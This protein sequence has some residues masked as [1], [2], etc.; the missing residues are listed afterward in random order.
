MSEFRDFHLAALANRSI[1]RHEATRENTDYV[2]HTVGSNG[3]VML[4][5]RV[6]SGDVRRF[7]L[8]PS[9]DA[10]RSVATRTRTYTKSSDFS[11][12]DA[13]SA[14]GSIP[15]WVDPQQHPGLAKWIVIEFIRQ[16]AAETAGALP[17]ITF[18]SES[19][20][21]IDVSEC[22]AIHHS[23][24]I[25]ASYSVG[26][27]KTASAYGMSYMG[28]NWRMRRYSSI[29]DAP[30][31]MPRQEATINVL[32]LKGDTFS[33]ALDNETGAPY[34]DQ[35]L[36][37]YVRPL[38]RHLKSKK[39]YLAKVSVKRDGSGFVTVSG[40]DA[41]GGDINISSDGAQISVS[42]E[43]D[44][45]SGLSCLAVYDGEIEMDRS[46]FGP[47]QHTFEVE[48]VYSH[49]DGGY[50]PLMPWPEP[51]ISHF[52]TLPPTNVPL[53]QPTPEVPLAARE[54]MNN[55][56]PH[57]LTDQ[58]ALTV[59]SVRGDANNS[60]VTLIDNKLTASAQDD[61][62]KVRQC[63]RLNMEDLS[64]LWAIAY[65]SVLSPTLADAVEWVSF[66]LGIGV[67]ADDFEYTFEGDTTYLTATSTNAFM[68]GRTIISSE[69]QGNGE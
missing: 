31:P 11:L 27:D 47:D 5:A 68:V 30:L 66:H 29:G 34:R 37:L 22:P 53:M 8:M 51:A 19:T 16:L 4:T 43:Y 69:N 24:P 17:K 57:F 64:G 12:A 23:G 2:S 36:E 42:V 41:S 50:S 61:R 7:P 35:Q 56:I 40:T 18:S 45:V 58:G 46:S 59:Q 55:W 65:E 9:I 39:N 67:D 28:E 13:L 3:K 48:M 60:M 6:R 26:T 20:V 44:V 54:M 63:A 32:Y 52:R 15:L 1:L 14:A 49:N 10:K 62:I 21:N 38:G 33:V 25:T